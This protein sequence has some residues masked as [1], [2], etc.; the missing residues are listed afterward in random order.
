M[1]VKTLLIIVEI[2]TVAPIY[3][4]LIISQISAKNSLDTLFNP[5]NR[6]LK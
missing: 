4:A 3:V 1:V 5:P 2:V 6:P